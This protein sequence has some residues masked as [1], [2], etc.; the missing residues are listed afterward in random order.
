[1]ALPQTKPLGKR[2]INPMILF[3]AFVIALP[4]VLVS[5]RSSL[6]DGETVRYRTVDRP[7][8]R[9]SLPGEVLE[10]RVTPTQVHYLTAGEAGCEVALALIP[11][12][13]GSAA[14]KALASGAVQTGSLFSGLFSSVPFQELR[15]QAVSPGAYRLAGIRKRDRWTVRGAVLIG[16][17]SPFVLSLM[18]ITQE[19]RQA[20]EILEHI[21]TSIQIKR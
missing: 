14:R 9:L 12:P 2:K 19:A 21:R 13:E 18:V 5:I 4:F 15:C 11:A 7:W 1:M 17:R 3:V 16:G 6:R 10:E 8:I 20:D